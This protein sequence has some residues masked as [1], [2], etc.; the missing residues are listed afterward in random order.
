[1]EEP[2]ATEDLAQILKHAK[3]N[4]LTELDLSG[5]RLTSLP[6]EIGELVTLK[7]LDLSQNAL[8]DLPDEIGNLSQLG[9]LD[10]GTNKL[11]HM[12]ECVRRLSNL[13]SLQIDENQLT[14]LPAWIAMLSELRVFD[15]S[16]NKLASLPF[17]PG[18]L[19]SLRAFY[20][21]NNSFT[22]VPVF[23]Q[24][25]VKLSHLWIGLNQITELPEWLY[26]ANG[27]VSLS[28]ANNPLPEVPGKIKTFT[29]L[30]TLDLAG[31][32]LQE[33]PH[34]ILGLSN[35]RKLYLE[36]NK[37]TSIPP[38]IDRLSQLEQLW[39]YK[40]D[41]QNLPPALGKLEKLRT[42]DIANNPLNPV[43]KSAVERGL[44]DLKTYL[45]SLEQAEP[46][47]ECKLV[48]VGE[49]KVGKTTLLKA[50]TGKEPRSEEKSTHGVSIERQAMTLP[51]PEKTDVTIQFN[52]WDFGGQ[53]FYR[54]THQ[55]FFSRRSIYLLVWEPRTGVQQCQVEDWLKL[56]RLRVGPQ[57]R[58]I[59]VSTH[60]RTEGR[61]ARIDRSEFLRNFGPMIRGFVEVDSLVDNPATGQKYGIAELTDLITD[62]AKDLEQ[63]GMPFNIQWRAARDELLTL[64][65]T[66][67]RATYEEFVQVCQRHGLN[68]LDTRTLAGLMHDLG[69]IVYYGEDERLKSD[70]VLQPE[71]LTKA[72]AFVL[73]DRLTLE[74]EGVLPDSHL[75]D[76]WLNHSF[77][78]EPRYEP[79]LYAFFL[80]LMEK[81][82][83][84]YRLEEGNA[85]LVAQHVPQVRPALPWLPEEE[86]KPDLKRLAMVYV[87]DEAPPGLVPWMIVRTHEFAVEQNGHRLH[88]QKGMFLK[89]HRHGEALL[90][91]RG[92]E[93][94]LYTEA[95]W[96]EYFMNILS[97]TLSKLVADN[98][99]GMQSRYSFNVPCLERLASGMCPG[100]FDINALRAFLNEGDKTIRCQQCLKKQEILELLF[101]FEDEEPREQLARIER[102]LEAGFD[103][104]EHELAGLQS[105][106]ANY[107]MTIMRAMANEAKDGPRLFDIA[108]LDGNW[109]RLFEKKYRLR[110][111][112][113]A[114]SCQHPVLE[115]GFGVYEVTSTREWVRQ[116][117]PYA[118]FIAGVMKTL[119]PML[120]PS[121]NL[122]F[123]A[124][125]IENLNLTDNLELMK[126]ATEGL[127][128]KLEIKDPDRLERGVLSENERSGL[129]AL[130]ALLR[131]VDP[132]QAKMGLHRVPTYTGD[133][134]WLCATHYNLSQPRIPD[135]IQ[136]N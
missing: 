100:R 121:V 124:K 129:L 24:G 38:D 22:S 111:W 59:I 83:V 54:V 50:L 61:I 44:P 12:P 16:D 81:Y 39:L 55:F 134:L 82:D 42:L 28:I 60:A 125:T 10:L 104:V 97:Q 103:Q 57:A 128:D 6:A 85:S 46:L 45:A 74:R 3:E 18:Q 88:W 117:A 25:N 115:E 15:I 78:D 101:G 86:P 87:M 109:R 47:Y 69:Y 76:V 65:Q 36:R 95:V 43:L 131:E 127:E 2:S 70:V 71:W 93:F 112:C 90:E 58:V 96:P 84:S 105:R 80:R 19:S 7:T 30:Y 133:F 79:H 66:Q 53:E 11:A 75:Q 63:M 29:Q 122:A 4:G 37:L 72:I 126:V 34:W 14:E 48:L 123:G 31:L 64:G 106:L 52:A 27:L 107:V 110:L 5:R 130:H 67:P 1:M 94:H 26:S 114:E 41:I 49:G 116:V 17:E 13:Q 119:V 89:N 135:V 73:E 120:G 23:I 91:L 32:S 20:A 132:Q 102:K 77:K 33:F 136:S 62:T 92:R 9:E 40:N 8:L 108:P 118:N 21:Q 51:H 35:L 68:D 99:P 98:W 113:E 56:I